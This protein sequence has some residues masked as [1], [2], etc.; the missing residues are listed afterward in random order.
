MARPKNKIP[1]YL[2][3]IASGQGRVRVNG[4]DI[5]LGPFGSPESKQA[6]ARSIA[7]NFGNGEPPSLTVPMGER[8]TV[9]GLVLK[10]DD[11]GRSYYVRNGAPTDE[12][13][14]I[15]AA[16]GPLTEGLWA[17]EFTFKAIL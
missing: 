8:L 9:A 15:R 11:F 16:V 1:S 13:Y 10:Y 2:P 5:Y 14:A 3:H 6:Y 4:R 7:E 12:R 17:R